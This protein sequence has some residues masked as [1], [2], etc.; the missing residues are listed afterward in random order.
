MRLVKKTKKVLPEEQHYPFIITQHFS[1]VKRENEQ[2]AQNLCNI[3]KIIV[4]F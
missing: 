3:Q 1:L 2:N 4:K